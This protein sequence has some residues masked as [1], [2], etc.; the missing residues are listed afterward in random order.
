MGN[1]IKFS[2]AGGAITVRLA[3]AADGVRCE[4]E[5]AGIGIAPEDVPKLF[6]RFS[7]L[8]AGRRKGGTGLG[9]SICKAFVEAHGGTIGVR[10]APDQGSVFWFVL[11]TG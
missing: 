8:E 9:L 4:V 3:R 10:S 5:D 7:Q 11:P 6:Q 1:A 2:P